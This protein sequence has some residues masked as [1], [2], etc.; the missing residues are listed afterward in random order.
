[1]VDF[2]EG[3]RYTDFNPKVDKVATYGI[4]ALVAGGLAAKL[5]FFKLFWIGLLA[6]KKFIIIGVVALS[7]WVRKLFK[8]RAKPTP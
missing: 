2:N 6:A 8:Q 1:M 5:G 7:A 4:A 3:N